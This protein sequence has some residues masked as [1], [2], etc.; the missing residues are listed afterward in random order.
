[1]S[2]L[3]P[4]VTALTAL[5][6]GVLGGVFFGFSTVVMPGLRRLAAP[7]AVAAMQSMNVVAPRS[8]LML[9]LVVSGAGSLAVAAWAATEAAAPGRGWL[10]AGAGAGFVCF[11]ITA[12]YHV[13]RN[14]ELATWR[15]SAPETTD[16]WQRYLREWTAMNHARG[17]VAVASAA[18]LSA[19]IAR[20]LGA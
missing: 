13:P 2:A 10:L 4:S 8:L 1:M 16:L 11:A 18:T 12:A 3:M 9:P 5:S 6:S 20:T 17:L 15:P 14:N 19:G 7:E